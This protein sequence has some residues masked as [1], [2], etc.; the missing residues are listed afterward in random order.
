MHCTYCYEDDK[1]DKNRKNFVISQTEIDEKFALFKKRKNCTEVELLGGEV[2]LYPNLIQYILNKYGEKYAFLI[3]TNGTI[4]PSELLPLIKKYKPLIGVSLDDPQTT[5]K[6]RIGLSLPVV[7]KNAHQWNK[8]TAVIIDAVITPHNIRRIKE[9]FD[10]YILEQGFSRIHFGV[11]E[12]WMN[13]HYWE[14]YVKEAIRLIS[15]IEKEVLQKI[16]L[17]PW[18]NYYPSVKDFIYEDGIEKVEIFNDQKFKLSPYQ[19][20]KHEIYKTYCAKMGLVAKPL[21]PVEL[22]NKA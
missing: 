11:V 22:K 9:T 12:E 7:L 19:K 6:Q 13:K 10:F 8:L 1:L 4:N 5:E 16:F 2:F 15:S 3:T 18:Q 20:A 14:V 17:S 21:F